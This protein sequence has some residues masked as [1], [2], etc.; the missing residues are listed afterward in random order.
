[1]FYMKP[2]GT[3]S[4]V[5]LMEIN[6]VETTNTIPNAVNQVGGGTAVQNPVAGIRVGEGANNNQPAVPAAVDGDN[7]AKEEQEQVQTTRLGRAI[8]ALQ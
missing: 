1:M 8:H 7:D 3:K 6:F 5:S 4:E 2:V